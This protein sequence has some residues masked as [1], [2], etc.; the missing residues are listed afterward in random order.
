[1]TLNNNHHNDKF[2]EL[3]Y[4]FENFTQYVKEVKDFGGTQASH[5]E[6]GNLTDDFLVNCTITDA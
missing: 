3:F 4:N 5:S 1:M 6:F 2:T